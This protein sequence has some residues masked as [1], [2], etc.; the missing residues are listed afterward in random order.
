MMALG[1]GMMGTSVAYSSS[2]TAQNIAD[3]LELSEHV[4]TGDVISV[5][6]GI[7]ANNVPYTE[8][9]VNVK[10]VIR[11]DNIG[12]T[13]T[14]RQFGLLEPRDM[15]NG[16]TNVNVIPDGWS[17]YASGEK[18]ML[19]MYQAASITGLRTTVGLNQGKF[20]QV[21][22]GYINAAGNGT[23]FRGVDIQAGLLTPAEEKMIQGAGKVKADVFEG[24]VRKAVG[25]KWIETRRLTNE[26]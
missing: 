12:A 21:D 3:L 18:V 15:G 5:T 24:F 14:F 22:G 13:Y 19:F 25:D 20:H 10:E 8:V 9:T 1:L 6:D 2:V 4:I 26:K 17:T 16:I 11:G 23:L 7:D